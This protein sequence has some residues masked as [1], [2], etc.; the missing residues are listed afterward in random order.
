L[1]EPL[2]RDDVLVA[3]RLLGNRKFEDLGDTIP[4]LREQRRLKRY[5]NSSRSLARWACPTKP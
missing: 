3:N 4:Q 1:P 2:G 5:T